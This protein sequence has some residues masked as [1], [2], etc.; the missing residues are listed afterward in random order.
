MNIR[1]ALTCIYQQ[2]G[3]LTP[4]IVVDEARPAD[5]A[6][7][8]RFEW[9]DQTAAEEY[10]KVQAAHMI[11]SVHIKFD[12]PT[13]VSEVRGFLAVRHSDD[14]TR[15]SYQ[16]TE[17]AF[18]NPITRR[19]L[20]NEMKRDWEAFRQK[21]SRFEEYAQLIEGEAGRLGAAA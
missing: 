16:P 12:S 3:E 19:L 13:G 2:R 9:D 15:S 6:L 18:E 10:R 21:Y 4:Q 7:H 17:V 14:E 8:S 20:I 1:D 5:S 11:R